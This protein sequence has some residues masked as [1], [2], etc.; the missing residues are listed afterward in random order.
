MCRRAEPGRTKSPDRSRR[1]R[2]RV[3]RERQRA[4]RLRQGSR[5][6]P[7]SASSAQAAR[8]CLAASSSSPAARLLTAIHA[9]MNGAAHSEHRVSATRRAPRRRDPPPSAPAS[10]RERTVAR[11]TTMTRRP[12]WWA[13]HDRSMSPPSSP[14]AGSCPPRS[15]RRERSTSRP[16]RGTASTSVRRSYWP[17][18][19][20]PGT[21]RGNHPARAGELDANGLKGF[22]LVPADELGAG[23]S[24]RRG[25]ADGVEQPGQG[26]RRGGRAGG[27]GPTRARR[28]LGRWR[29][30]GRLYWRHWFGCSAVLREGEPEGLP[31]R[32][33]PG[34]V[35]KRTEAT[36]SLRSRVPEPGRRP[37]RRPAV[38][39][40]VHDQQAFG[41][42]GLAGDRVESLGEPGAVVAKQQDRGHG[43]GG[44]R[45]PLKVWLDRRRG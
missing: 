17:W 4:P 8:G 26:V 18:S 28:H 35:W 2:L 22:G 36:D 14:N 29:R 16:V 13:R 39:P 44:G 9:A 38:G 37:R 12:A 3:P 19:G 34:T 23:R 41:R 42:S 5:T 31:G 10:G 6:A 32:W 11:G 20:S 1:R 25:A 27:A 33:S 43:G 30:S 45:T 24:H 15:S 7:R 21:G 40:V